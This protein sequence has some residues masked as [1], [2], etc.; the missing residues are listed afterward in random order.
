[1]LAA[2]FLPLNAVINII[3]GRFFCWGFLVVVIIYYYERERQRERE[4][5]EGEISSF[6]QVVLLWVFG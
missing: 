4:I 5:F 6:K 1:M 3:V 2:G